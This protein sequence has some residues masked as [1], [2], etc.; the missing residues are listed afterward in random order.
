MYYKNW[1][2]SSVK[3]RLKKHALQVFN[4]V[5]QQL[6]YMCENVLAC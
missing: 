6:Q 3:N 2:G 5:L 1:M 4:I